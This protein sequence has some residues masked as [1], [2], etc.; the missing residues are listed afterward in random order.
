MNLSIADMLTYRRAHDSAGEEAFIARY[1][2][3]VAAPVRAEDGTAHA[4]VAAIPD[5]GGQVPRV[6]FCAHTDSV[7]NRTLLHERQKVAFDSVRVEYFVADAKQRDC[8]GADDAAGCYVLLRMLA[9]GVPGRYVFFRGEERG[10]IGSAW[11]TEN[12]PDLFADVDHAI[13]F[14][15]KGTH[16]IITEMACGRTCSDEFAEA[17]A[18][19]LGI[20][21]VS[22]NTGS[23]TDTAHLAA[24][25]PECTNV[26]VG[27]EHEHSARETL[28]ASYLERLTEACIDAFMS[29]RAALP[30]VREAGDFGGD[31]VDNDWPWE[32]ASDYVPRRELIA[33]L[34]SVTRAL[35]RLLPID[36]SDEEAADVYTD[37]I[38][39]IGLLA[40]SP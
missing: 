31:D 2:A 23:F 6:A 39:L 27:Y 33:A 35:G 3:P 26:S 16:S 5:D 12:R 29:P 10:G 22:D 20:G 24:I 4:Y 21:H 11:I 25:V 40:D 15:R 14:D 8:L 7:H 13:Q 17:L 36:G 32:D 28:N 37:A 9:A 1:V 34:C 19:V 38:D 18:A 30:V